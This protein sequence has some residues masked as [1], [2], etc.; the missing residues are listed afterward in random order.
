MKKI[1]VGFFLSFVFLALV[2]YMAPGWSELGSAEDIR[3][4]GAFSY[5]KENKDLAIVVDLELAKRRLKEN[6]FP[7]G[8]KIAN[9]NLD[10]IIVDRDT[11]FLVDEND[12]VY[13]M[14]D[15]LEVQKNYDKLGTD[16]KFKSQT[17]ILGDELLTSFS[18]FQKALSNFFPQTQGAARVIDTVFIQKKGYME[19]LIYFPMPSGGIEGKKLKLRLDVFDLEN[20][21]EMTFSIN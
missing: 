8:I 18:Y 9:K 4:I 6:Y 7:L 20:P 15:I 11:L 5:I 3:K 12:K 2:E 16:H 10:S 13:S 19:D 1:L 21:F 17:G 14:P